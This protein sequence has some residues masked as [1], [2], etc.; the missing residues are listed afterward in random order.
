MAQG[1]SDGDLQGYPLQRQF[2]SSIRYGPLHDLILPLL[3]EVASLY[4]Q[5]WMWRRELGYLLHEAIVVQDGTAIADVA[6]GN[7]YFPSGKISS[8]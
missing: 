6:C 7:W 1:N 8:D 5:H 3:I 2:L 4:F